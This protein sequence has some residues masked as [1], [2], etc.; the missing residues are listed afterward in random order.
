M[1]LVKYGATVSQLSGSIGGIVYARN[2]GGAYI[3]TRTSPTQP[4]SE[5][6]VGARTLFSGAVNTWTNVLT[7]GERTAWNAYASAIPYTDVF[8][9]TRYYSGQQRYVQCY[10]ALVNCGGTPVTA[11]TAPS[12]FT[13]AEIVG[14]DALAVNQGA[15]VANSTVSIVNSTGP[16]DVA[17]GDKLLIHIGGPITAAKNYFNG[18]WRYAASGVYATGGKYPDIV[19]TDPWARTLAVGGRLAIYWRVLKADNRISNVARKIVTIGAFV[20]P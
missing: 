9:E 19:A 15:T 16:S 8:G 18:P 3:R 11:A 12:I 4:N 6:Q 10:V 1:A 13:A 20:T 14:S 7:P 5:L 17:A 2:K